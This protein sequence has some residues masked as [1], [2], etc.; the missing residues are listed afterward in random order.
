VPGPAGASGATG[1]QGI[2]GV[3]GPTGPTGPTGATGPI[4]NV[5]AGTGLSGGGSTST[6]TVSLATPVSIANGG[7][8]AA[9][10]PAALTALGAAPI[11]SPVFTGNP[12]APTPAVGDSDT[13]IA[14]TAFVAA[15]LQLLNY[16]DNSGFSI[17]QRGYVSGT[18]LAAG[19]YGHDRWKAGAGG[20]TYTFTQSG[21]PATTIT[22]TA[23]TLQQVIEGASV[24]GG[25]Y[26]LS[27]TGTAQ[28]RVGAGS[29]A[30]SPVAVAGV[31]AGANTTIEFNTG[32]LGQVK[33][34]T[35]TVATSW[36]ALPAQ[37]DMEKCARFYTTGGVYFTAYNTAGTAI[38]SS[39]YLP[40]NMRAPPTMT[41]AASGN[42]NVGAVTMVAAG[43]QSFL[44]YAVITATGSGQ[45][46]GAFTASADL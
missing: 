27:W 11:A 26:V 25:N 29:Y 10:A 28:G 7:T 23:G 41:F 30:A 19:I 32:T 45:I 15:A 9:T 18:A 5:V 20:G 8:S 24:V 33:L 12:T 3:V 35:G 4:G 42:N 13:S 14:T 21:G 34:A 22:I 46:Q 16:A 38:G 17:N 43:I 44:Y 40:S 39:V 36:F 37:Q 1:P 31:T 2:Q 6:V